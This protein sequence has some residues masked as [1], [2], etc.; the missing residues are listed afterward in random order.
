MN[1]IL[2]TIG[3]KENTVEIDVKLLADHLE[4]SQTGD[5]QASPEMMA[6]TTQ[7]IVDKFHIKAIMDVGGNKLL[8]FNNFD[9]AAVLD[10]FDSTNS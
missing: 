10:E 8:T 6:F 1:L 4:I 7:E 5:K 2:K 3:C 9:I